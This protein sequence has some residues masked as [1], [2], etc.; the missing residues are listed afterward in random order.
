MSD[1]LTPEEKEAIRKLPRERMP[2]GLEERVVGAMR[3]EGFLAKRRRTF[4]LTNTRVAGLLAA[5]VAVVIGAY[6]IGLHR[7]EG[8]E[9][10]PSLSKFTELRADDAARDSDAAQGRV[11]TPR[12]DA[13]A[14]APAPATPEPMM[15]S[16]DLGATASDEQ[17]QRSHEV[18]ETKEVAASSAAESDKSKK[19]L[20][21]QLKPK[22][23]EAL[24]DALGSAESSVKESAK[25]NAAPSRA[26]AGAR[27]PQASMAESVREPLTFV[28]DGKTIV[29]EAPDSVRVVQD[30]GGKML[31]IY[32][33]DGVIRIRM[34]D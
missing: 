4:V 17:R 27:A 10:V 19:D 30:D 18:P 3:E 1:E 7:G 22:E 23:E 2:A 33:S 16:R 21:W 12:T 11:E 20:V 8:E 29:I 34:T 9:V 24:I 6:S 13:P 32:T 15:E 26:P 31:L 5:S 25:M 28:V 14:S